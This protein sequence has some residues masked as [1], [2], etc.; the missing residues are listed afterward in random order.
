MLIQVPDILTRDEVAR[1]RAALAG[2]DW[3]DGRATAGPQAAQVKN[4]LQLSEEHPV[5]RELGELILLKLARDPLYTSA[6]L[7]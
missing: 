4:N 3:G 5:A 1:F 6:P 2:A 7:P